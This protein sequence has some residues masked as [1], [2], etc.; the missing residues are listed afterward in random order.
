MN[1]IFQLLNPNNTLTVNRPLAHAIGLSEAIAY[2]AL[3]AK[4]SYYERNGMLDNGWFYST[5]ADLEESTTLSE[6]QQKRCIARLSEIGLIECKKRGMPAK[7]SF[8]IIDNVELLDRI[9]SEGEAICGSLKPNAAIPHENGRSEAKAKAILPCC[10]KTA[11]QAP[12]KLDALLTK[13]CAA[14]TEKTSELYFNKSKDNKTKVNNQSI[15]PINR[16]E[17]VGETEDRIDR[18]DLKPQSADVTSASERAEYL[19]LIRQNIDYDCLVE[20]QK[21]NRVRVDEIVNIMLDIVCSKREFIRVNG[22]DFP[23]EVVKS[24]FLK[25]NS[26]HIEYVLMALDKSASDIRN[27]RSYL[28]TALYNAPLTIDSFYSAM[29]NHDMHGKDEL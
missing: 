5:V 1:A 29:V 24:Q 28:I 19:D 2:A 8:R 13:N 9:I 16:Q 10:E 4:C 3:I 6:Y 11:E 18:I 23:Q 15:Y 21:N 22:E 14:A 26:E 25:L 27:I 12:E 20:M 7:R 17:I